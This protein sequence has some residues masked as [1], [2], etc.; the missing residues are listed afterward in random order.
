M[1][2]KRTLSYLIEIMELNPSETNCK[3]PHINTLSILNEPW[4]CEPAVPTRQPTVVRVSYHHPSSSTDSM[5]QL[6]GWGINENQTSSDVLMWANQTYIQYNDCLRLIKQ[7][8]I[9]FITQDKICVTQVDGENA[10][11]FTDKHLAYTSFH[12][13]NASAPS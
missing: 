1:K 7:L 5:L 3:H 8:D 10:F 2:S 12:Y 6:A 4:S 13:I 9:K 11:M